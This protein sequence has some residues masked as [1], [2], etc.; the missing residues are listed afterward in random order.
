MALTDCSDVAGVAIKL[1]AFET[2]RGVP[3]CLS[4]ERWTV[5]GGNNRREIDTF[6]REGSTRGGERERVGRE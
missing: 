3:F 1:R 4:D 5:R 6:G 2:E